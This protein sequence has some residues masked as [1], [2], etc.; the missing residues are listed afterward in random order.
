MSYDVV[1]HYLAFKIWYPFS[2]VFALVI[3][4]NNHKAFFLEKKR[5]TKKQEISK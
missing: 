4:P 5:K 1:W 3:M 2:N